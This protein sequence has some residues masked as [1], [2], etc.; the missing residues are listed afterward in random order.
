MGS[1]ARFPLQLDADCHR[2]VAQHLGGKCQNEASAKTGWQAIFQI[3]A[4]AAIQRVKAQQANH[5][6]AVNGLAGSFSGVV[7]L[8]FRS[9][10]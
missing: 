2:S 7:W 10:L 8:V 6:S 9:F 3:I 1:H 4:V 5:K